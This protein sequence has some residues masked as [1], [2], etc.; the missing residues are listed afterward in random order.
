MRTIVVS[1]ALA[2]LLIPSAALA[3]A[4]GAKTDAPPRTEGSAEVGYVST[5]GNSTTRSFSLGGELI[6]RPGP[7]LLEAKV[8]FIRNEDDV[9]VTAQSFAAL[10]R[11][12]RKLNDRLSAFGQYD[13][14][15]DVFAGVEHRSTTTGGLSYLVLDAKPHTLRAAAGG[16]Y[17]NE[18][19]VSAAALST[20]SANLGLAYAWAFSETARLT[21]DFRADY[22][23]ASGAGWRVEQVAALT[24]SLTKLFSLKPSNTVRWAS[25]PVPGFEATDTITSIAFVAKF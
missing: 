16:G 6:N 19:R 1:A 9:A 24:A 12:S 2:A 10:F 23:F 4:A 17:I 20:G 25:D 5:T 22:G 11:G 8:K 15:R 7:W 3:Q 21:D 18:Q 13:Y 14:L